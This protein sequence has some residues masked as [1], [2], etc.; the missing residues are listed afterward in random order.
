MAEGAEA[1]VRK[2]EYSRAELSR[3]AGVTLSEGEEESP[4]AKS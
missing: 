3:L 1:D 2:A 4:L